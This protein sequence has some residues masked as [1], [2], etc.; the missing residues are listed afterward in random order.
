MEG[1]IPT[2]RLKKIT[3]FADKFCGTV[4]PIH[5]NIYLYFDN[6]LR[7]AMT[8]GCAN[9]DI[10]FSK[11]FF[12]FK[13]T[14]EIPIQHLKGLLKG[15]KSNS[16][17]FVRMLALDE[18]LKI[19]LDEMILN[20]HSNKNSTIPKIN[21]DKITFLFE[22]RLKKFLELLDFA[23]V[24]SYEGEFIHFFSTKNNEI[25]ALSENFNISAISFFI[26]NNIHFNRLIP[27]TTVRHIIKSLSL[28]S[29]NEVI[30]IFLGKDHIILKGQGFIIS[31]CSEV[32]EEVI[33][34]KLPDNFIEN[35][36]IKISS[37]KKSLNRIYTSIP[38]GLPV[39]MVFSKKSHIVSKDKNSTLTWNLDLNF[40][41]NYLVEI[42]PRKLRSL[43]ARF[44]NDEI[45][46]G[47][48][49]KF[50]ALFDNNKYILLKV[51][52]YS[53]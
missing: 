16:S 45:N 21:E 7:V 52:E 33:D 10:F 53:D 29:S 15:L 42:K 44:S 8:D 30:K 38:Q 6:V 49:K 2:K 11:E 9:A 5:R 24:H 31:T 25:Y 46:I 43:L 40:N 22:M 18:G 14:Y 36:K 1:W 48:S 39:Y 28:I 37:L 26:K 41:H 12:P 51:S 23:S 47:L 34:F 3:E 35:K 17:P 13:N 4:E 50:I 19:E 20:I 32:K 27:F